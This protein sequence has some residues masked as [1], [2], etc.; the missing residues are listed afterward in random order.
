MRRCAC[1][2]PL[3]VFFIC[4]P[5][6]VADEDAKTPEAGEKKPEAKK[7]NKGAPPKPAEKKYVEGPTFVGKVR[8]IDSK[9]AELHVEVGFGRMAKTEEL[10]LADDTKYL[11][12]IHPETVDDNGKAKKIVGPELQKLKDPKYR[13]YAS[14]VNDVQRGQVVEV[15]LGRVKE[16][17][18]KKPSV[19]VKTDEKDKLVVVRVTILSD[20]RAAAAKDRGRGDPKAPPKKDR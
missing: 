14:N 13:G 12:L 19:K 18:S 7:D 17:G 9:S 6:L 4:I 2:M 15:V 20:D 3:F 11:T 8:S 16:S 10:R 5:V 1:W